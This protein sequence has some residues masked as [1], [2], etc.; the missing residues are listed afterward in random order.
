MRTRF[1][2]VLADDRDPTFLRAAA[3]QALAEISRVEAELSPYRPGSTIAAINSAPVGK[4]VRLDP[5]VFGLLS[6][7]A[8]L[9]T[10]LQGAFDLSVGAVTAAQRG[11]IDGEAT[12]PAAGA[13]HLDADAMT[14]TRLRAPLRLDT[15]AVGKGWA[16]ERAL[17]ILRDIGLT[18]AFLH[19]GTSSVRAMGPGPAGRGWK[20]ALPDLVAPIGLV[21]RSLSVSSSVSQLFASDADLCSHIIDPRTGAPVTRPLT[22]AVLHEDG[23]V[24]EAISTALVVLGPEGVEPV[25][26]SFP[27]ATVSRPCHR[28]DALQSGRPG[29]QDLRA[30]IMSE[31]Q[32]SKHTC[33]APATL[34]NAQTCRSSRKSGW[35]I[36]ESFYKGGQLRTSRLG[37]W[38]AC[39]RVE[40]NHDH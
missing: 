31:F 30:R 38:L 6:Q 7:A 40:E 11:F 37:T 19:G 24:A 20:V 18:N 35:K 1:E 14:A 39:W 16:L 17:A 28:H 3:E 36:P 13:L 15:G 8:D 12:R 34:P 26:R 5:L 4:A 22:A 29:F 32:Q 9:T 2:I 23:V 25:R 10:K 33:A 21:D 27:A